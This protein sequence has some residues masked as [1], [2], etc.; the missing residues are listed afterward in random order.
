MVLEFVDTNHNF[1]VLANEIRTSPIAAAHND[2]SLVEASSSSSEFEFILNSI[3]STIINMLD[4]N[5]HSIFSPADPDQFH[6]NFNT[7]FEF[8]AAFENKCSEYDRDVKRKL[9]ASQAYKYFV[10]KWPIHVYFQIR[11]QEIVSQFEENLILSDNRQQQHSLTSSR[12]QQQFGDSIVAADGHHQSE[13]MDGEDRFYLKSTESLIKSMEYSWLENKCFLKC[14]LGY[15]WKLNLQ[16]ISRYC[17]Y[18]VKL[19]EGKKRDDEAAVAAAAASS[20]ASSSTTATTPASA[21]MISSTGSSLGGVGG[22]VPQELG[23]FPQ[24]QS[25]QLLVKENQDLNLCVMLINDVDK[26]IYHRVFSIPSFF[27]YSN[28][29][30][31]INYDFEK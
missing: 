27:V 19:F 10:K 11:F 1:L 6:A 14:L 8:L 23:S 9:L 18:Y 17:F 31:M 5:L 21:T 22:S 15:F 16:L 24:Q 7:S 13:T 3:F 25:N 4:L 20:S 29:K 30:Q 2:T 26:L 12:S 28:G